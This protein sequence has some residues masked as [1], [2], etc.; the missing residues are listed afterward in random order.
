[1]RLIVFVIT[2]KELHKLTLE[3]SGGKRLSL[4]DWKKLNI[5]IGQ[6]VDIIEVLPLS[7]LL[8]STYTDIIDSLRDCN[9]ALLDLEDFKEIRQIGQ[10][11]N[12]GCRNDKCLQSTI[13]LGIC[14]GK[15]EIIYGCIGKKNL[16]D[17]F[18]NMRHPEIKGILPISNF[19]ELEGFFKE[20]L[21]QLFMDG[22]DDTKGRGK[23]FSQGKKVKF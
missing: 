4:F 22:K 8:G 13:A 7:D 17:P 3:G 5:G 9:C 6:Y 12:H 18:T 19:E 20:A 15:K 2:N 10:G 23:E 16:T 14:L 1:M 21:L 11:K